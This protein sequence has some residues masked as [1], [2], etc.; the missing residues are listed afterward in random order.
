MGSPVSGRVAYFCT[1][2]RNEGL[3]HPSALNCFAMG[4]PYGSSVVFPPTRSERSRF[5]IAGRYSF[6]MGL[7]FSGQV[8]AI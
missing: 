5:W 8:L 3:F 6:R 7:P 4:S 1:L 2:D